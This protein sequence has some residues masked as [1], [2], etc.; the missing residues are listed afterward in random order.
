MVP[1]LRP[2]ALLPYTLLVYVFMSPLLRTLL[3]LFLCVPTNDRCHKDQASRR[4][5]GTFSVRVLCFYVTKRRIN[6]YRQLLFCFL[7][8]SHLNTH[9]LSLQEP[10]REQKYTLERISI[11][12]TMQFKA[13]AIIAFMALTGSAQKCEKGN[14]HN[15]GT[16]CHGATGNLACS[17]N[18]KH[19]VSTLATASNH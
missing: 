15:A 19:V 6:I 8:I 4:P 14:N 17:N 5:K 12:N 16:T 10:L 9:N 2:V 1:P 13:L 3:Q 7:L 18:L 11:P